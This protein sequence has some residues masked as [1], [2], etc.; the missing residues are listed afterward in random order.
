[1]LTYY[2]V[3][4]W[5]KKRHK[6]TEFLPP[7]YEGPKSQRVGDPDQAAKRLFESLTMMAGGKP[8]ADD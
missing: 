7:W 5:S 3:N 2:L 4:L 8:V 1:M 6:L